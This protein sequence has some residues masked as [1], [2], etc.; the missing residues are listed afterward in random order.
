MYAKTAALYIHSFC[1]VTWPPKEGDKLSGT[2]R[3]STVAN[4][5]MI[6]VFDHKGGGTHKYIPTE[7]LNEDLG[8]RQGAGVFSYW[9]M[10]DG[11]YLLRTCE[12]PLAYWSGNAEDKAE[13]AP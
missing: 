9:Q 4:G 10:A 1:V 7:K 13:R 11:S 3:A 6:D 5:D 12:G 8:Y 2:K